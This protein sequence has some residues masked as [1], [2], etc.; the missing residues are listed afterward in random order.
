MS[1]RILFVDDE[2]PAL[3]SLRRMLRSRK[4]KW[5]MTFVDEPRLAWQQLLEKTFDLAVM[6]VR[7]PGL[8]GLQLLERIQST[9]QTRHTPVVMLSGLSK[10]SL[11][12]QVLDLGAADLLRKPVEPE[13]LLARI[14]NILRTSARQRELLARNALLIEKAEKCDESLTRCRLDTIWRLGKA[15]ENR[16]VDAG[17]HVIRVGCYCRCIAETLR[18]SP[19]FVESIFLT[20]PLHDIGK[21]GIPDSV[22]LHRGPLSESQWEIMKQ[23]CSIGHG[24]LKEDSNVRTAYRQ[25][26]AD[27]TRYQNGSD[28]NPILDMAASIALT[29]HEKWDGSGYP[30][31]LRGEEIPLHSRI[32]AVADVFDALITRRPYKEACYE[33]VALTTMERIAEA[34]FDS[35][36][37]DAFLESLPRIRLIAAQFG[38]TTNNQPATWELRDEPSLVC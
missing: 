37:F 38:D 9:P 34:H 14:R 5:D 28:E 36:V 4:D 6:D 29:H 13:D 22:L 35:R 7:M 1:E 23:H 16:D 33:E 2:R 31:G 3:D 18:Q 32:V 15:S 27:G 20:A 11:K 26:F 8:D 30:Q 24:I 12:R 17:D 10:R 25:L 21:I 19:D